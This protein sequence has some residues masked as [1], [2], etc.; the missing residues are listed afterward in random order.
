MPTNVTLMRGDVLPNAGL[1]PAGLVTKP[2]WTTQSHIMLVGRERARVMER[3]TFLIDGFDE[4]MNYFIDF[5]DGNARRVLGRKFHY[6][7]EKAGYYTLTL[8]IR[9]G[10]QMLP[11]CMHRI[12]IA[13]VSWRSVLHSLN[14]F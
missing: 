14:L 10:E 3:L 4:K 5:G 13:D 1:F 7:F 12:E 2:A 8:S 11:V 6:Q 9:E